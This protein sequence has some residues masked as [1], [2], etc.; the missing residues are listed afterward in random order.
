MM[1]MLERLF[2]KPIN[3]G[4]VAILIGLLY[5]PFEAII[6]VLFFDG[7]DFISALLHPSANEAWMR[8]LMVFLFVFFGAFIYRLQ[9]RQHQ[10]IEQLEM[11]KQALDH[12]GEGVLITDSHGTI[13][14]VNK[15]FHSTT[16]FSSEE[17]MGKNPR[18]LQSGKQ[19]PEFYKAMWQTIK[20]DGEWCGR[21]WNQRKNGD[22][23]P[24]Q[25]H[26]CAIYNAQ[27]EVEH[28]VGVFFDISEQLRLEDQLRQSQKLEAVG[29]LAGGIA[30][31][32]NN[33]LTSMTGNLFLVKMELE[34]S[35]LP[36]RNALQKKLDTIENEGF[37]A[38]AMIQHLLAFARKGV[39]QRKAFDFAKSTKS[40]IDLTRPSIAR[41][42][43]VDANVSERPLQ[44]FG[45]EH[46][47]E[48]VMINLLNN[49][50]DAV[51]A[52]EHPKITVCLREVPCPDTDPLKNID[53]SCIQLTVTDNGKGIV[54][55]DL[56]RIFEPFFTTKD[57]GAGTGLGL[58]M[59]Y[60]AIQ[61][62]GGHIDMQSTLGK[63]S[64]MTIYL[65]LHEATAND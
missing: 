38:A 28:H 36:N 25:L 37:R 62:H 18:M 4:L 52:C 34:D 29:T 15:A 31:D 19:P 8:S 65:P 50:A 55:D 10:H 42:I 5:W 20:Q 57:V 16:G 53:A 47:L 13:Q 12:A 17:V 48:E 24:E 1:T 58:S 49:A 30:H 33:I 27:G 64:C 44:I 11:L 2:Y 56:H 14:Y 63:G 43:A 26:I 61:I 3:A 54:A 7:H 45:D 6:H 46:Q 39:V 32:F 41:M 60:G 59:V 22:V 35:N 40:I 9:Q 51:A 23:Y 21:I